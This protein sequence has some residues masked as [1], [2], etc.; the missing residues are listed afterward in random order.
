MIAVIMTKKLHF[1]IPGVDTFEWT[2]EE[3][4]EW[5]YMC[6]ARRKNETESIVKVHKVEVWR[7]VKWKKTPV[8]TIDKMANLEHWDVLSIHYGINVEKVW[9]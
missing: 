6:N 7:E 3:I 5:V 9:E 4:E 2:L 8:D 1:T